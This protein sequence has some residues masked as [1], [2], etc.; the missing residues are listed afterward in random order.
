MGEFVSYKEW[1]YLIH[2]NFSKYFVVPCVE[3]NFKSFQI[4]PGYVKKLGILKDCYS[5]QASDYYLRPNALVSLVITPNLLDREIAISYLELVN[6]YLISRRSIGVKTLDPS[7]EEYRP[8][9]FNND[10]SSNFYTAHGFNYHN[11]PE[12]VWLYAYYTMALQYFEGKSDHK[13]SRQIDRLKNHLSSIKSNVWLSLPELT[14]DNGSIC[15]DSC[16]S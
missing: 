7:E 15:K 6:K 12:W 5:E 16:F 14:N 3:E 13:I 9:Y 2:N 1:K 11:G 10:D 4:E 8:N